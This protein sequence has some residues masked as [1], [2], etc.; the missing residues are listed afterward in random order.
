MALVNVT[1]NLPGGGHQIWFDLDPARPTERIIGNYFAQGRLYEPDV[2]AVLV[3]AI[4]PGDTVLDVGANIGIFS[5]LAAR[6]VGPAGRVVGFEPGPDNLARL[7]ANLRLNGVMNVTVV[8]QP[9]SDRIE[10]VTFHLNS[11]NEGAHSLWNPANNP[12]YSRSRENPRSIVTRTTT[13]DAEVARLGLPPPRLIK[14]DAEGA[15]HRVLAG[16]IELFREFEIPY[17]IAEL[18]EFAL[19]EMGS[20]QAELRGFMADLGY[21]TF[22]LYLDGVLPKLVPRGT[23]IESPF[24]L[25]M[26]FS[27][28]NDVAALW[29]TE[30]HDPRARIVPARYE[31]A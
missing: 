19:A 10:P 17:V 15:E 3:R 31:E 29:P 22:L 23:R 4:Q 28:P 26:L 5:V 9:V 2:A 21:D 11:D 7:A 25:N 12:G 24:V 1:V 30:T 13:I 6:L 16:A 18:N 8:D 20:S 27:T 14:I